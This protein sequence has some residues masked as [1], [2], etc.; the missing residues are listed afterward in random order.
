LLKIFIMNTKDRLKEF[1]SAKNI[2][3]NKF[4]F[5]IGVSRGYLSTKSEIISSEV[6]EKTIDLFPDLN[7]EWLITGK[8][9]MFKPIDTSSSIISTQS[10]A[11]SNQDEFDKDKLIELLMRTVKTYQTR[12]DELLSRVEQLREENEQLKI[13]YK[14]IV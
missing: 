3:R 5:Q 9:E 6:I 1:L 14:V 8:G 7:L 4:E 11:E 10:Q 12:E 2:G 13:N